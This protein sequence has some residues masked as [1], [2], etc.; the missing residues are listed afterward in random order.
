VIVLCSPDSS[1]MDA[2]QVT[3]DL[4]T[5]LQVAVYF[6]ALVLFLALT[7]FCRATDTSTGGHRIVNS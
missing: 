6:N 4:G 1:I 5:W 7:I 3:I 2:Y